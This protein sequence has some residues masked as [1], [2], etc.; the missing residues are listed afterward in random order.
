MTQALSLPLLLLLLLQ[1][2]LALGKPIT[3][4]FKARSTLTTLTPTS[5][6]T[7]TTVRRI[8]GFTP[9]SRKKNRIGRGVAVAVAVGGVVRRTHFGGR[10]Y[11]GDDRRASL[12][13]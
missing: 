2:P 7:T 13:I 6:S 1:L 8:A 4:V 5:T 9:R 11:S 3:P 12:S 10:D